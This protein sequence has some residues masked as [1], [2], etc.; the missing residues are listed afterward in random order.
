[1]MEYIRFYTTGT[2]PVRR[3]LV[4]NLVIFTS[5]LLK[6]SPNSI[7]PG[8]SADHRMCQ[9]ISSRMKLSPKTTAQLASVLS[10]YTPLSF[11]QMYTHMYIHICIVNIVIKNAL[12]NLTIYVKT[13]INMYD[14]Y[15]CMCISP[16]K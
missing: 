6:C 8:T 15:A 1:M 7:V 5:N 2:A 10:N 11:Q 3:A 14:M 4:V 13:F 16:S 12:T 9:S